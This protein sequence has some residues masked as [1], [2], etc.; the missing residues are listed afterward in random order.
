MFVILSGQVAV[1]LRDGLG[2][3]QPLVEQGPGQ[4]LAEAGQ[5]SG[6]LALADAHA[7]GP[8]EALLLPPAQLRAL[9]VA[10]AMLGERITRALILRRVAL[11]QSGH[12]GPLVI[13]PRRRRRRRPPRELPRPQQPSLQHGRA[14]AIR[15]SPT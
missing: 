14:V 5:L 3:R 12:G 6:R 1:T 11:I 2:R 9:L 15:S 10:E 4:F 13:G 8:V 7:E